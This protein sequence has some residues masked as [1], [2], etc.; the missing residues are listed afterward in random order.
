MP[1]HHSIV[2]M[3]NDACEQYATL[4][5]FSCLG[6]TMTFAELDHLSKQFAT[7]L[8]HHT[9]LAP[10]DRIAIQLPNILQYPVVL[11]GAIRAGIVI[12]NTNPLYTGKELQ[13]QLKD[14]GAKVLVV[15][16]NV[17]NSVEEIIDQ[18]DI[19]Q[20]IL[21]EVADLHPFP[22][23]Q[24]IN[25]VVKY[26]KKQV[27]ECHF[28]TSVSLRKAL[29][30][31][32]RDSFSPVS[33][34][35]S[36]IAFLQYTGGTTGV[37]KGAIL[38]HANLLA[39]KDQ[40]WEHWKESLLPTEEVFVAPLPLY[41][42]YGFTMHCMTLL[43]IGC[44]SVLVPNPR[45]I[46][47]LVKVFTSYP[48]TGMVGLN[49][50]FVA[51]L[52]NDAFKQVDFSGFRIT[53][54]GGMALVED[55]AKRWEA[56]TGTMVI[57]GYGLTETS[58]V[59][60]S[61]LPTDYQLGSIGK[62]LPQTQCKVIDDEGNTLANDEVGEL[63]VKG[64]Q[65][66]QGYWERPEETAHALD[67]QGWFKTGDVATIGPNGFIRI[68]DRKKDMINVSGFNV[69]PNEVEAVLLAHPEILEAAVVAVPDSNSGEAVKAFVVLTQS[70]TLDD[71]AIKE[72]CKAT[73]TAYKVPRFYE[74]RSE[75]P[76]TTVGKVLRRALRVENP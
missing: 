63:C 46:P 28:S 15:L 25:G 6:N 40:I 65:V 70:S 16:A 35:S 66:M 2:D 68:V 75:L 21:T 76:K 62:A 52:N 60:S 14:S 31:G 1:N 37:A 50:L 44:H 45:D 56:L 41:H 29:S 57:E 7:Y 69:Y 59:V 73:L 8:Q 54:A 67:D 17:A 4:D 64:P 39:N 5:A 33:L 19:Q 18:T 43:S 49:T 42:I 32:A 26:I 47:S 3:F 48:L 10:G 38:T 9:T 20:V 30:L 24:L 23:R 27:P 74:Y 53:T 12:V 22:K 61:N 11:F 71:D 34:Q 51:L 36:D 13:G 55:T 72:F 58:P